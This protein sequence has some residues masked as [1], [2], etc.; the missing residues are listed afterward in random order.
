[1]HGVPSPSPTENH[2]A[3]PQILVNQR[4][5][6][7]TTGC[8]NDKLAVVSDQLDRRSSFSAKAIAERV[9]KIAW[10]GKRITCLPAYQTCT[11]PA[12]SIDIGSHLSNKAGS[13][14]RRN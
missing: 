13:S 10:N 4:A 6:H 9:A 7:L 5:G 11:C 3:D 1:M 2:D 14:S 12:W 8:R